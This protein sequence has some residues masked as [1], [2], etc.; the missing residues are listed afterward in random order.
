MSAVVADTH[1]VT[2]YLLDREN[3]SA[4]ATVAL[5]QAIDA[6]DLLVIEN[7]P[8][9]RCPEKRREL[10]DSGN[11]SCCAIASQISIDF[12]SMSCTQPSPDEF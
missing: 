12:L 10:P 7:I 5:E 9:V 11:T 6:G 1:T 3:L 4:N 2:W 8:V